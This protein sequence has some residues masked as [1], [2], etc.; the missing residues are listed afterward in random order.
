MDF[1]WL[2][3][4]IFRFIFIPLVIIKKKHS[5]EIVFRLEDT[6]HSCQLKKAMFVSAAIINASLSPF[7]S[8]L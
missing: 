2:I 7:L 4:S 5:I 6:P 8:H 3:V 1:Y